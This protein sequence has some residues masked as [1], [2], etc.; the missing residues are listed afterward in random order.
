MASPNDGGASPPPGEAVVAIIEVQWDRGIQ[1]YR[2][3]KSEGIE[4]AI[5]RAAT[6][7]YEKDQGCRVRVLRLVGPMETV[8]VV[9]FRPRRT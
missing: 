6:I 9:E 2:V 7:W 1:W 4:N 3:R 5:R 8:C